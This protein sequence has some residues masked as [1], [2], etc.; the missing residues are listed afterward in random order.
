MSSN[1]SNINN[2]DN[3]LE[4]DRLN[5]SPILEAVGKKFDSHYRRNS[6]EAEQRQGASFITIFRSDLLVAYLEYLPVCRY[7][8][9]IMS[10]QIHPD[11]QR[12][13][14]LRDI[15]AKSFSILSQHIP[16][17]IKSVT[18]TSNA[19]SLVL[20]RKLGFKIVGQSDD[21]IF[22]E[23]NG[24]ALYRQLAFFCKKTRLSTKDR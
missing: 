21:R 9:E 13:G 10:L 16:I 22:L 24:I 12:T 14:I 17:V 2:I 7:K 23:A 4:L 3:I 11:Y 6:I 19:R 18:H 20:H 1:S 15:L 8:W 5:I